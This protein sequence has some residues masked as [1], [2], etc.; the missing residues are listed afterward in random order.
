MPI[1]FGRP[2]AI[3]N[4]ADAVPLY[5]DREFK[6]KTRSTVTLL[7]LLIHSRPVFDAI[8]RHV[9]FPE[10][11]DLHLEYMVGPLRGKGKASHTDV[12]LLHGRHSLAVEAKWTEPMYETV[13]KWFGRGSANKTAVR[14]GWIEQLG[15]RYSQE[16][17]SVIYQMLHRAASAAHAGTS[18]Q[19]A[20]LLFKPS[21]DQRSAT[22]EA[23]TRELERLW[24]LLSERRFP[25]HVV[26]VGLEPLPAFNA[27][28]KAKTDATDDVVRYALQG[29]KPLFQFGPITVRQV[30]LGDQPQVITRDVPP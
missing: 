10:Q 30:G 9:G 5:G 7:D 23:I 11:H 20:Y 14:D 16:F 27:L 12:M 17:D 4:I 28:P 21:P 8:V 2:G 25:F 1:H 15:V 6:S 22:T 19:L 3:N 18:P 29:D 13:G 24:G 26:E